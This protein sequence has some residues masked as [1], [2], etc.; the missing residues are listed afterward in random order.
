MGIGG[1]RVKKRKEGRRER[2]KER[3]SSG[4]WEGVGGGGVK[5][6]ERHDRV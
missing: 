3:I 4:K 2:R 5:L 1:K 6:L